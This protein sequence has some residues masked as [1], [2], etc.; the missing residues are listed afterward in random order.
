MCCSGRR[1][2]RKSQCETCCVAI[3]E[4]ITIVGAAR[5]CRRE[6]YQSQK[7]HEKR[8]N[9]GMYKSVSLNDADP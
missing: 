9:G 7:E 2:F 6:A 1:I 3:N 4:D 5:T 8:V